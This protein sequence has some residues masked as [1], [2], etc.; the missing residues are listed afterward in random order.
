[1]GAL[2]FH[3][4][5]TDSSDRPYAPEVLQTSLSPTSP[6]ETP[7]ETSRK[8]EVAAT[9]LMAGGRG[10]SYVRRHAF[11]ADL[12]STW[13]SLAIVIQNHKIGFLVDGGVVMYLKYPG[14]STV[15]RASVGVLTADTREAN[16][17]TCEFSAFIV[18]A[19]S[20][21]RAQ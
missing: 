14:L 20:I 2:F 4:R 7:E 5:R 6:E 17:T 12:Y 1:R 10:L 16:S 15:H 9:D 11:P 8:Q 3:I 19:G 13:T 21:R 18:R